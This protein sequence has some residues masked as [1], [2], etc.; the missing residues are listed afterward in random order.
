MNDIDMDNL[1]DEEFEQAM[2]AAMADDSVKEEAVVEDDKSNEKTNVGEDDSVSSDNDDI[3]NKHD[4]DDENLIVDDSINQEDKE[5]VEVDI[6][7]DE[8]NKDADKDLEQPNDQLGAKDSNTDDAKGDNDKTELD[9]DQKSDEQPSDESNKEPNEKAK[10]KKLRAD[11][12]DFEFT[13]EERDALA[14]KGINYTSKMKTIAPWRKSISALEE[15]NMTHD[16]LN[17][18]I[19]AFKGDKDAIASV[20][21]RAGVDALDL[22]TEENNKFE[23]KDYGKSNSELAIEDITSSIS[24]DPEY[25]ITKNVVSSQWDEASRDA[26]YKNPDLISRLHVD[27]KSGMYDKVAPIAMKMK[28]FGDGSKSD[29][30]YYVEAGGVVRNEM[31]REASIR[32]QKEENEK[33]AKDEADKIA[34]VKANKDKITRDNSLSA[35]RKSAA[36][37]KSSAGEKGVIDYLDMDGLS[38]DEF[39]EMM[40][41]QILKG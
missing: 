38:D 17:L 6:E 29:L 28:I 36:I 33:L 22:D 23:P 9:S 12:I 35:K 34:K 1:S 16:D 15:E 21:K 27:V 3:E 10:L 24:R 39:S 11:G 5:N 8:A 19:D 25:P 7:I 31:N 26:M 20:L 32:L 13:E 41:K 2:N 18:M 30:E 14:Q 37:T 4:I 40:D